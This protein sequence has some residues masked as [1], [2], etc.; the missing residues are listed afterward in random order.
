[1]E[2]DVGSYF[3]PS[4][5]FAARVSVEGR[6]L[7]NVLV[8]LVASSRALIDVGAGDSAS[9]WVGL[10]GGFG[11]G[12]ILGLGAAP[13]YDVVDAFAL[14]QQRQKEKESKSFLKALFLPAGT[15]PAGSGSGSVSVPGPRPRAA[16]QAV[17]VLVNLTSDCQ[18][19]GSVVVY[20]LVFWSALFLWIVGS[21]AKI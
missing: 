12:L 15:Q 3:L 2:V 20:S 1:M 10:A 19:S 9:S 13:Q 16:W 18:Q 6:A 4:L 5:P 8:A 21:G 7:L 17:P 11:A 14:E